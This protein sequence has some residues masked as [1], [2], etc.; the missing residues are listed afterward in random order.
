[1]VRDETSLKTLANRPRVLALTSE[2]PWPL[3]SG[4]H[5]RTFH[6]LSALARQT[7]LRVICPVQPQQLEALGALRERG[8][9]VIGPTVGE[10]TRMG[11]AR[12]LFA[13][14]YRNEPYVMYRRHSWEPVE[15]AIQREVSDFRP[16]IAYFDHL[17]SLV[18]Q[19]VTTG[20][21]AAVDLHNVYSLLV[22]RSAEE[23]RSQ[24]RTAFLRREARLLDVMERQAVKDSALQFA[25]SAQEAAHFAAIGAKSVHVI[26][27]GVDCAAVAD[28][29]QGAQTHR[30][31]CSWVQC[32]GRQISMPP[33]S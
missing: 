1:M 13:A 5:I 18:Y 21:P 4:G 32:R 23:H 26:P 14:T 6:L 20:I 27:N 15:R 19:S 17:D 10:R 11:E 9:Q 28:L 24:W 33:I 16:Q 2:P 31:C 22:Q 3:N 8:L 7:E 25:V 29:R 30:L 12:R